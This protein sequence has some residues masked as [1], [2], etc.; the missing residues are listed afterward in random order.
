MKVL[1]RKLFS[2]LVT[3]PW[4]LVPSG[5][6]TK[7]SLFSKCLKK[8]LL[9]IQRLK[10]M[11]D[12]EVAPNGDIRLHSGDSLTSENLSPSASKQYQ[13]RI[14]LNPDMVKTYEDIHESDRLYLEKFGIT[15]ENLKSGEINITYDNWKVEEILK[16]VIP[17]DVGNLTSFSIIGHIV[18]VNIK[19]HLLAYKYIIGQVLL[20]KIPGARTV[21]NKTDAIDNTYRNF[22]MEILCGENDLKAQV[23]ENRCIFEFDFSYVYWNPRLCTEHERILTL[24][25]QGDVL[26]D[27]FAGVGPFSIPAAR[28]RHCAFVL[29]NDLNPDSYRWLVHNSSLNKVPPKSF[30][31]C[32]KDGWDFINEDVAQVIEK[33][34]N[35]AVGASQEII[36]RM[37]VVMNLPGRATEFLSAFRGLF[38]GK[39]AFSEIAGRDLINIHV[40]CFTATENSHNE[41][42]S[43]V[44]TNI[45]VKLTAKE[46]AF[47]RKVSPSKEMLRVTFELP[48]EVLFIKEGNLLAQPHPKRIRIEKSVTP[49]PESEKHGEAKNEEAKNEATVEANSEQQNPRSV[50][51]SW[52]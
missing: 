24:I 23:R 14:L 7:V 8:Y 33:R 50:Q 48:K 15:G 4:I 30:R 38:N 22:Q 52:S 19:E 32:N 27:V 49:E 3:I 2:K 16:S 25:S 20:D 26:F 11:Q 5:L 39:E 51:S 41:A 1:D 36:G 10:P 12:I 17:Q 18:H 21:V 28:I 37:H 47:V 44:E 42:I 35:G 34:W 13:K 46:V 40:Y 31:A 29:A 43:L 45:G 9:K 6:E